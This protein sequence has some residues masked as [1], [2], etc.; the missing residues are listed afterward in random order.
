MKNRLFLFALLTLTAL[1]FGAAAGQAR[2]SV[3]GT[4]PTPY[5]SL[6]LFGTAG[7]SITDQPYRYVRADEHGTF[8]Q[9]S[10]IGVQVDAQFSPTLS[11]T[12][13]GELAPST[14]KDHRYHPRLSWAF[15]T[16]RPDNHWTLRLGKVRIP[17][18]ML[19]ENI[20][21]GASYARAQLPYEIF[22]TAPVYDLVGTNIGY[23]W[24]LQNNKALT[25]EGYA[26]FTQ[27]HLRIF[28][29]GGIPSVIPE[30]SAYY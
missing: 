11:A 22:A 30:N 14:Y 13:Q 3:A 18:L 8:R 9:L 19:A 5:Y 15:L 7:Y 4:R 29:R 2:D 1:P 26:G 27:S 17:M 21:V 23:T 16:Y 6:A 12:I 10:R 24:E 28:Y 25:L 20:P